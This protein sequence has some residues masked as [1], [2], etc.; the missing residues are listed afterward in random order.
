MRCRARP[1]EHEGKVDMEVHLFLISVI[2]DYI[3]NFWEIHQR[4][5]QY[6]SP[7]IGKMSWMCYNFL[8]PVRSALPLISRL[9]GGFRRKGSQGDALRFLPFE[10][11]F[12]PNLLYSVAV[13]S[14]IFKICRQYL[15]QLEEV[16][17][18]PQTLAKPGRCRGLFWKLD[19][20]HQDI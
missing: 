15:S 6:W 11:H 9:E 3:G 12:F 14:N 8:A 17:V 16:V 5:N 7:K 10:S 2:T 20:G 18:S 4:R 13:I 19:L 1:D